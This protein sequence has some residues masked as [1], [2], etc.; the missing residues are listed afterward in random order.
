RLKEG[1]DVRQLEIL[2]GIGVEQERRRLPVEESGRHARRD[3]ERRASDPAADE[4]PRRV[5][6]RHRTDLDPRLSREPAPERAAQATAV[7]VGH[8]QDV[9]ARAARRRAEEAGEREAGD[10]DDEDRCQRQE[11]EPGPVAAE[12]AQ[13]LGD[14]RAEGGEHQRA[15]AAGLSSSRRPWPVRA[16]KTSARLG[17]WRTSSRTSPPASAAARST[18]ATPAVS[19]ISTRASLPVPSS[20]RAPLTFASQSPRNAR[21]VRRWRR[22]VRR[23]AAAPPAA[24][25]AAA[26]WPRSRRVNR[27]ATPRASSP[28]FGPFRTAAPAL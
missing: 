13:V 24:G 5:A 17:R 16:K 3:D 15:A 14:R 22:G 2:D 10:R 6:V 4:R 18:P 21:V 8:G 1:A 23:A 28:A 9:G 20:A 25:S 26:E 19:V 7:L 12:E 11:D 27:P